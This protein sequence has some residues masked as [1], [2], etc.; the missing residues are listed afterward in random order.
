MVHGSHNHLLDVYVTH[1]LSYTHHHPPSL[2]PSPTARRVKAESDA[3]LLGP[4]PR[5]RIASAASS[6]SGSSTP[7]ARSSAGGG[8]GAAAAAVSASNDGTH[9]GLPPPSYSKAARPRG[10]TQP[11]PGGSGLSVSSTGS[12]GGAAALGVA[13]M[14]ALMGGESG[15]SVVSA[16]TLTSADDGMDGTGST[17]RVGGRLMAKAMPSQRQQHARV[18]GGGVRGAGVGM[19][20]LDPLSAATPNTGAGAGAGGGAGAGAGAGAMQ[21]PSLGTSV[22]SET[23]DH[24]PSSLPKGGGAMA[25]IRGRVQFAGTAHQSPLP[26]LGGNCS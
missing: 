22:L 3:G 10:G 9:P 23:H 8:G 12:G 6:H 26:L 7:A 13:A 11:T 4:S 5:A 17:P 16:S 19:T 2:P 14:G 18:A 15:S 21:Q 1:T 24:T 25:R 20:T